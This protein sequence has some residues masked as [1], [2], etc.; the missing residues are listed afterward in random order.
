MTTDGIIK[1]RPPSV[2]YKTFSSFLVKLQHL[3]VGIDRYNWGEVVSSRTGTHLMPVMRFLNLIDVNDMPTARLRFLTE[4]TGEH[5]AALLRQVVCESYAFVFR[6]ALDTRN[7]TYPELEDVFHNTYKMKNVVCRKCVQFFI[8]F[9]EDAGIQLSLQLIQESQKPLNNPGIKNTNKKFDIR[10]SVYSSR[11]IPPGE[12]LNEELV[13]RN[14]SQEEFARRLGMPL[15]TID[16]IVKGKKTITAETALQLEKVMP[17]FPAR[18][19]LYLQSDFQLTEARVLSN[20]INI[21]NS[22]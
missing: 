17:A 19:W 12:Y 6:G 16:E 20:D 1:L 15:N 21:K 8:E 7:A 9:S 11:A 10:S 14:I 22:A 18:F 3:H 2:S 4:A 5:R 13:A